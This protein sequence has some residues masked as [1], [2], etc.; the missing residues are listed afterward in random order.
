MIGEIPK[1]FG[2]G[3]VIGYLLP[4][5]IF[6]AY[7]TFALKLDL[8]ALGPVSGF[9]VEALGRAGLGVV[10]IALG[11]LLLNRPFVRILEGYYKL[12]PLRLLKPL[13]EKRFQ[14]IARPVDS[15]WAALEQAWQGNRDARPSAG[16]G[17]S[18]A[19]AASSFPHRQEL[20]LPTRFGNTYRAYEVYPAVI[21]GM[22]AVVL[23]PRLI[24]LIP[25][26]AQEQL[27]E[28]RAKLD[29]HVNMLWLSFLATII[30]L[31]P[32][33]DWHLWRSAPPAIFLVMLW[34]LLPAS[35]RA[36]GIS[37]TSMFDLY[38]TQLANGLGL[39]L[40]K[41][42][43]EERT[44]WREV[45]RF[46]LYRRAFSADFLDQYRAPSLAAESPTPPNS[47]SSPGAS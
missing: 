14:K 35:A 33:H 46:M 16:F 27:Q 25:P 34:Y 13:N 30:T 37:F 38:R 39:A 43:E 20:I 4:A 41:T 18:A 9:S 40:P 31:L 12:N 15:E 22:D 23:W 32:L 45:V 17:E 26:F 21:Y 10:M 36:W 5:T 29:F 28:S 7:L 24:C 44:M 11:L 47:G 19:L 2:R 8:F 1:L 3:F 6:L 42:L